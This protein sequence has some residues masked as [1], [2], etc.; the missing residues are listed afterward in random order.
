[1][2]SSVTS[3]IHGRRLTEC[4]AA[5]AGSQTAHS[6]QSM[7]SF[8][9]QLAPCSRSLPI[10]HQAP[11]AAAPFQTSWNHGTHTRFGANQR[12][13]ASVRQLCNN[14]Q[15]TT[16]SV[17][18]RLRN[19]I[20][21]CAGSWGLSKLGLCF[22]AALEQ[23]TQEKQYLD[24]NGELDT[25]DDSL[26][27]EFETEKGRR[28]L[29]SLIGSDEDDLLEVDATMQDESL[30]VRQNLPFRHCLPLKLPLLFLPGTVCS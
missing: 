16:Q 20:K 18:F 19:F 13:F 25:D 10:S 3:S 15:P 28:S 17:S 1:M 24:L 22:Q 11:R 12:A 8:A 14:S 2:A 21:F 29:A 26:E 6:Q 27:D 7:H 23:E 30:L 5:R 9:K 4:P